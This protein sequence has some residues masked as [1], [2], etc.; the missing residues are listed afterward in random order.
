MQHAARFSAIIE[1][2]D[3]LLESW[4]EARATPADRLLDT[5]FRKRRYIGSKDR[6]FIAEWFYWILRHYGTLKW[7]CELLQQKPTPR[8]VMLVSCL[9]REERGWEQFFS[10]E[11]YTPAPLSPVEAQFV[12]NLGKKIMPEMEPLHARLNVPEMLLPIL[13]K[14]LGDTLEP[15]MLA[16]QEQ[17]PADLR[18]NTLKVTRESLQEAL[19]TESIEAELCALSPI[20]LRM[21]ERKPIFTTQA[22]K[23]GWFEMQ[24]EGSQIV[25]QLADCKPGMRVADFCAG[26]GGK[27][28][29]MAAAMK[30]KG[31]ILAFDISEKRLNEIKPRLKR[32]G[33]DNVVVQS[34]ASENDPMLKRHKAMMDRVLVDAP[35]SGSGTW[36]RNP[37]LKWR[38]TASGFEELQALQARILSRAAKLVKPGGRLIYATCSLFTE[39]NEGQVERLLHDCH[40]FRVVCAAQLWQELSPSTAQRQLGGNAPSFLWLTPHQDGTDGF[41][42]AVLE[43]VAYK[44]MKQDEKDILCEENSTVPGTV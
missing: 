21:H 3:Q 42:A 4:G 5:Y 20:G 23:N 27:T 18:T 38:F 14:S 43:R 33:V 13:K 28:L 6:A 11:P 41:F 35:C 16:M 8:N 7:R 19:K 40:D 36:R 37:D 31:K 24:D 15:E 26:A 30:N 2:I 9:L 32:A 12:K 10:G 1:L 29:A 17:A 25:A 34:I 39:E 44:P 22:F